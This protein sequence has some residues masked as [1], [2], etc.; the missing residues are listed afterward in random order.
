MITLDAVISVVSAALMFGEIS[1]RGTLPVTIPA[2]GR[3]EAPG[4]RPASDVPRYF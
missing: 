1:P 2:A 4:D 3:A